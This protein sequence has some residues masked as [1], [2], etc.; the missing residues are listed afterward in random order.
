MA[1]RNFRR[2]G[3]ARSILRALLSLP[4][5]YAW[6]VPMVIALRL[7]PALAVLI[8][9][10]T[11]AAFV[12]LHIVRPLRSKPRRVAELRFRSIRRYV[13]WL[14][15]AVALKVLFV[16]STLALHEQLAAWRILPRLPDDPE[17]VS[18]AFLAHPLGPVAL[19]LAIA[20]MAPLIE[21]FAFRGRM[22]HELEHTVGVIPAIVLT[23]AVFSLLHGRIDAAHHLVFGI[24]A[25]WVVWRTGSL[26]TAVYMHGVNNAV[27]VTMVRLTSDWTPAQS[28]VPSWLWPYALIV[29]TL[30]M[31]GL[32]AT[33]GRIHRAAQLERPRA[34]AWPHKRSPERAVTPAM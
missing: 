30:A 11:I 20:I 17:F 28:Q 24:F 3:P 15:V 9:A 32:L 2:T 26:W 18:A 21:E 10:G 7:G 6:M 8:L 5:A 31:G 22:Q 25:G 1:R 12:G 29:A 14:T 27:A 34:G 33:G 13:P 4:W 19:F 16:L 23:G